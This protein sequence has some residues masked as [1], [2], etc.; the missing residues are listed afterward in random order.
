MLNFVEQLT[1][2]N[3]DDSHL[4]VACGGPRGWSARGF[5]GGGGGGHG[6][7]PGRAGGGAP[8][9][10]GGGAGGGAARGRAAGGRG[11]GGGGR[12]LVAAHQDHLVQGGVVHEAPGV[13]LHCTAATLYTLHCLLLLTLGLDAAH[14]GAGGA[15]DG[16]GPVAPVHAA[17]RQVAPVPAVHVHVVS[18]SL[19]QAGRGL[20]R[21]R[22]D[23][24]AELD[25]LEHS[26]PWTGA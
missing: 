19:V 3:I 18:R 25:S 23:Y 4:L 9:G 8:A 1:N 15:A 7:V 26:R 24:P 14:G 10:G 13:G 21:V 6:G 17:A 12:A 2:S 20:D 16:V 22:D 5:L 11:A